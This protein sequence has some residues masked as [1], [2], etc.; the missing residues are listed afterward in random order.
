MRYRAIFFY[1]SRLRD[2][3]NRLI[4]GALKEA[5]LTDIA[6]SH[7]DILAHLLAGGPCHMGVLARRIRRTRS[8]MTALV[9]KLERAGYVERRPD[10]ADARGV[11]VCLT[12]R[13]R[14]WP[15]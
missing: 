14:P 13:A 3:G 15:R 7:G 11:L 2:E 12:D 9:E 4:I 10:P 8:T 1:A 5:G 6:P